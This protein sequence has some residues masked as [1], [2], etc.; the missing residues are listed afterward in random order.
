MPRHAPELE[1]SAEDKAVLVAL[2]RSR[3]AE[4]HA[5]ERARIILA[6]LES[7]EIQQVAVE[8]GGSVATVSKWRQ[9]FSLW[10]LKGLRDQPRPGK[11]I[12]YD[13]FASGCWLRWRSLLRRVCPTG[14]GQLWRRNSMPAFTPFGA[15]C[16]V[17]ESTCKGGV[18][19]V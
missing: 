1:C 19:G 7:K 17:K 18:V 12:R 11:P 8:L 2:A 15:S 14:T 10:G 13:S 3:T 9:R 16:A 4:A 6:C 5:V